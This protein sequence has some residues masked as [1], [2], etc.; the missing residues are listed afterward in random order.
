MPQG[1]LG[2]GGYPSHHCGA[3]PSQPVR[4]QY[5]KSE[6]ELETYNQSVE[7]FNTSTATFF[8]CIQRYVDGAAVDIK[9]IKKTV[10]AVIEEAN[11]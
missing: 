8:E 9:E 5:F 1:N 2:D 11:N 7:E 6:T 3:K 10:K 4:P